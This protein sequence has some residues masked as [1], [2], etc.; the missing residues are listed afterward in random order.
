MNLVYESGDFYSQQS[1]HWSRRVQD[2]IK[3]LSY[4]KWGAVIAVTQRTFPSP[5]STSHPTPGPS[6]MP[7]FAWLLRRSQQKAKA[8]PPST[9]G[10]SSAGQGPLLRSGHINV[11]DTIISSWKTAWVELRES[12]VWEPVLQVY[13]EDSVRLPSLP[14]FNMLIVVC[15]YRTLIRN[16]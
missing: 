5:P 3:T 2:G 15:M 16:F 14:P 7:S 4:I 13:I 6:P 8:P 12:D 1:A 11:K 10:P 9:P